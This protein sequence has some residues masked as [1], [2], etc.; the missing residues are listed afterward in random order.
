[1]W[2]F[3]GYDSVITLYLNKFSNLAVAKHGQCSILTG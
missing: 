3:I 2:Y 1:M